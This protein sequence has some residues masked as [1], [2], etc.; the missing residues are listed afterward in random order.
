[1]AA[2]SADV[3]VVAWQQVCLRLAGCAR[4]MEREF[5]VFVSDSLR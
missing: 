3:T 4:A 5:G 2:K 1:M